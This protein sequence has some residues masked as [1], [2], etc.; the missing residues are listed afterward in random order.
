MMANITGTNGL[1]YPGIAFFF[2]SF[3]TVILTNILD[4]Q[5]LQNYRHIGIS[6]IIC[7]AS[8]VSQSERARISF[9]KSNEGNIHKIP[10][11]V[12]Y[13]ALI[14]TILAEQKVCPRFSLFLLARRSGEGIVASKIRLQVYTTILPLLFTP[15][16]HLPSSS[17][18]F[19]HS[20]LEALPRY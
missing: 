1:L 2:I 3:Y 12:V 20:L 19:F 9:P 4:G 5:Q 15:R 8:R 10:S 17:F 16:V 7:S 13:I 14:N 18:S 6:I 11:M